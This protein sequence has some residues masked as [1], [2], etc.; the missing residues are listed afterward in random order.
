MGHNDQPSLCL[1]VLGNIIYRHLYINKGGKRPGN[2]FI[3]LKSLQLREL[4]IRW[5]CTVI[6]RLL[7]PLKTY[8]LNTKI[9]LEW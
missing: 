3:V 9:P 6:P 1:V 2:K 5:W 4:S 8:F 7:S